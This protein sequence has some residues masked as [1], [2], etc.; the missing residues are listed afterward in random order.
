MVSRVVEDVSRA[1]N[2][3]S[4]PTHNSMH[5]AV[6]RTVFMIGRPIFFLLIGWDTQ[7]NLPPKKF[8][9]E[10]APSLCPPVAQKEDNPDPGACVQRKERENIFIYYS[11]F[12]GIA[13]TI[14]NM[15]EATS[16]RSSS[17]K[18]EESNHE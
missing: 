3:A 11:L 7:S 12:T 5:T 17:K 10:A 2:R 15:K 9:E 1:P 16:Y 14:K 13:N 18:E 4:P 8:W 6:Q